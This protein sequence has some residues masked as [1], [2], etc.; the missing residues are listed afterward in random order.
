MS[1]HWIRLRGGWEAV[2][3]D[4]PLALCVRMNLPVFWTGEKTRR[5]RLRRRF[6]R[7]ALDRQDESL[8]LRI[9]RATGL[10]RLTLNGCELPIAA[11]TSGPI[12]IPLRTISDRNELVLE[13]CYQP[14]AMASEARAG[15]WGEIALLIRARADEQDRPLAR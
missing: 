10:Y 8:W 12:E 6:G 7:P 15:G 9:D 2:D 14:S 4:D 11:G 13:V 3:L 1:E 5:L